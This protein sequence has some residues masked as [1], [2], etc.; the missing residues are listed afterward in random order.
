MEDLIDLMVSNQSPVEVSDRIKE[1]I[2]QKASVRVDELRPIVAASIF[3][4]QNDI[5]QTEYEN[6]SEED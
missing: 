5:E 6:Q 1:L 2:I 4:K 3:D